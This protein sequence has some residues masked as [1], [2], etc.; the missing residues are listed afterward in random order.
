MTDIKIGQVD[1][2]THV[3]WPIRDNETQLLFE[4]YAGSI[5]LGTNAGTPTTHIN[6]KTYLP[7]SG[8]TI[9][10]YGDTSQSDEPPALEAAL[11]VTPIGFQAHEDEEFICSVDSFK[12]YFETQQFTG[13]GGNLFCLI[14]EFRVGLLNGTLHKIGYN[15]TLHTPLTT[16]IHT[17]DLDDSDAP[18]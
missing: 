6:F 13:V 7:L 12:L 17:L 14:L 8:N 10:T 15:V 2:P 4:V 18:H 16:N 11:I 9:R 3:E 5:A 1:I